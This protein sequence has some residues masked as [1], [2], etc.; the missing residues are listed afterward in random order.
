MNGT[1]ISVYVMSGLSG[2]IGGML[3]VGTADAGSPFTG[4]GMELNAIAAVIIGGGS[5]LGGRGGVLTP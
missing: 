1:L 5:F 4:Q 2:T 3:F